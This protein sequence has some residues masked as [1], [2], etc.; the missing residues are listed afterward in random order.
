MWIYFPLEDWSVLS[1]SRRVERLSLQFP[2]G[3]DV[4]FRNLRFKRGRLG[5]CDLYAVQRADNLNVA[6]CGSSES[7]LE[8]NQSEAQSVWENGCHGDD[9]DRQRHEGMQ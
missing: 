1:Y 4:V 2:G 8:Q 5:L 6:L 3:V 7:C 9:G